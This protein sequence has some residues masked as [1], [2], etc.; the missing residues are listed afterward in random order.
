MKVS[1]R[2][3]LACQAFYGLAIAKGANLPSI[4]HEQGW[5]DAIARLVEL[6]YRTADAMIAH[7]KKKKAG[8]C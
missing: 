5:D 6:S 1:E 8:K 2:N 3:F 4:N 7:S